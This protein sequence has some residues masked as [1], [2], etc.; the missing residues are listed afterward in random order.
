MTQKTYRY[1]SFEDELMNDYYFIEIK[2]GSFFYEIFT[3]P[4]NE[5]G[6]RKMMKQI[7]EFKELNHEIIKR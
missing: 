2:I 7:E 1:G 4:Y 5:I 6:K 3:Y